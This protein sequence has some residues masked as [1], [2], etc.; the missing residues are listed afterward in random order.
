MITKS[1][2]EKW[3]DSAYPWDMAEC[4]LCLVMHL[5]NPCSEH[6]DLKAAVE[7]TGLVAVIEGDKGVTDRI[8]VNNYSAAVEIRERFKNCW[9]EESKG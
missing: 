2:E 5:S 3:Y 9:P 4:G 7:K 6:A 8:L 1:E